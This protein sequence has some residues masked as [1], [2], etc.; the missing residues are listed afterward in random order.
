MKT[1]KQQ[2]ESLDFTVFSNGKK[3]FRKEY[4]VC[5]G[6]NLQELLNDIEL[7][8][9]EYHNANDKKINKQKL[10]SAQIK[11]LQYMKGES[12]TT[13]NNIYP[14]GYAISAKHWMVAEAL[15]RKGVI[16]IIK[17][18]TSTYAKTIK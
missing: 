10:S 13:A 8:L 7:R 16:E 15:E 1:L 2:I 3:A 11:F 14:Q 9:K 17:F 4:G 12:E 6:N 5:Y 18:G